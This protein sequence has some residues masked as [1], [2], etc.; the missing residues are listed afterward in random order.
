ME[1]QQ[2][3]ESGLVELAAMGL[4]TETEAAQVSDMRSRYAEVE[5]AWQLA[6]NG[7][8]DAVQVMAKPAPIRAKTALFAQI[9]DKKATV[10]SLEDQQPNPMPIPPKTAT[11]ESGQTGKVV[12][13]SARNNWQWL[14]A[15]SVVL[16]ILSG[17]ANI[18]LFNKLQT[19]NDQLAQAEREQTVLAASYQK[20]NDKISSMSNQLAMAADP[21]MPRTVMGGLNG[22][23]DAEV[24]VVWDPHK[25]MVQLGVK[26]LP[27]VPADKDLQLWAIVAGKPVDLGIVKM[28][29][30]DQMIIEQSIPDV[31]GA[32]A[33]A[34]TLEDKGG[35]PQPQGEMWL[36][37]KTAL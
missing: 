13:I 12:S 23:K 32:Q 26:N 7:L 11:I 2:F 36:M 9:A 16:A 14:A 27:A 21:A 15:A 37:G 34:V 35:H 17:A 10:K 29:A 20:A 31:T 6:A 1:A 24:L 25:K 22:A 18:W 30:D 33:F 4:A 3:I 28:G 8:S 19:A 5:Q